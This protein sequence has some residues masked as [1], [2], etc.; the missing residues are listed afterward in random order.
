MAKEVLFRAVGN[1]VESF[2][3]MTNFK[4]SSSNLSVDKF[5]SSDLYDSTDEDVLLLKTELVGT[6]TGI[7]YFVFTKK[8][9]KAV[10]DLYKKDDHG[11]VDAKKMMVEYLKEIE[12]V[13]AAASISIIAESFN[14]E[15]YGDVPKIQAVSSGMVNEVINKEIVGLDPR[16][17]VSCDIDIPSIKSSPKL[18]WVF[19]A[20]FEERLST[21]IHRS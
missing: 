13:I 6:V 2:S 4:A 9:V 3:S 15:I 12:N 10:Y 14:L 5:D 1:S 19:G 21:T 17:V 16:L 7:N 8:E 20:N 18:F 11:P